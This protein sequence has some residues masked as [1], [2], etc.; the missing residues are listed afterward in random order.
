MLLGVGLL[1]AC[2]RPNHHLIHPVVVPPQVSTWSEDVVHQPLRMHLEWAMPMAP[3]PFPAVLV[4]PD[5]GSTAVH[6][7]GVI[8]DLACRGYLA[9]AVDYRRF[10][11]GKYHRTLFPWRQETEVTLAL[12]I[13]RQHP[14][15]DPQRLAAIGFSQGGI[16]SLLMAARA[17]DIKAV[18]A[19]YPVSDFAR[20]LNSQNTNPLRWLMFRFIRG[21]FRRQSGA[22][23]TAEFATRLRQASALYQA[24][25]I[26]AP[27]L[28]IHGAQDGAAPVEESIRLAER[29]RTLD[30]TV[31]LLVIEDGH[32]V[33]NF[34]H[35]A[36]ARRAWQATVEWLGRYV[37]VPTPLAPVNPCTV[38]DRP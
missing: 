35:P 5:G 36:Q 15:V 27:V 37:E 21:Y 16:F 7:R 28:L 24:E 12:D 17:A 32:H 13:L 11:R 1:T 25:H 34:K 8:W 22:R 30:R 29:L 18:V 9:L 31:K 19:Y 38:K 4:H 23:S 3:G 33:F 6:M 26:Q 2:Q 14:R 10:E 20:W